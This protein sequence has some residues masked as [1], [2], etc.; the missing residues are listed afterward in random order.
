MP[1]PWNAVLGRGDLPL[2]FGV[3]SE[4]AGRWA[5]GGHTNVFLFV[6]C[7]CAYMKGMMGS[8]IIPPVR[9]RDFCYQFNQ[10]KGR[11]YRPLR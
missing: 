9:V 7:M 4:I 8:K 10:E 3:D 2:T 11:K 5:E 6:H 1:L